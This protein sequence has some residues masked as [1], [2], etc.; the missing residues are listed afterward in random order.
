[1]GKKIQSDHISL[2]EPD[3][4]R[5]LLG[6]LGKYAILGVLMVSIMLTS[7]IMLNKQL[8]TASNEVA[9][10]E[11]EIADARMDESIAS[12]SETEITDIDHENSE[13]VT[14]L[15]TQ[16]AIVVTDED[17]TTAIETVAIHDAENQETVSQ[18]TA[19]A[20]KTDTIAVVT[21][22]NNEIKA[23]PQPE[24]QSDITVN[25]E[26][27]K[28]VDKPEQKRLVSNTE[29]SQPLFADNSEQQWQEY[30]QTRNLG[31]KQHLAEYFDRIKTRDSE[32]LQEYKNR[33]DEQ[34]ERLRERINRQQQI[35]DELITRNKDLYEM[36][37][38]TMKR[39]QVDREQFLNR[40]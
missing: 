9:A 5:A 14:E 2:H 3:S 18:I 22:E 28:T 29:T 33:Q 35:I 30:I 15:T 10:I 31:H 26:T 11:K 16:Q 4:N 13:S 34:I 37:E 24:N 39:Q 27:P 40:I 36:K 21:E 32:L 17:M 8:G 20:I 12:N 23:T 7:I 25:T 19:P 6:P 38:A 1:M